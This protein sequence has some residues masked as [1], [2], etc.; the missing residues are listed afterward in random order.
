MKR[1]KRGSEAS[2]KGHGWPGAVS[3]FHETTGHCQPESD[4]AQKK[5]PTANA[6]G[7]SELKPGSVLLSHGE[8]PHYHR[9]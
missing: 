8:T 7:A 1:A 4:T 6:I 5:A 9:R 3:Y 2:R